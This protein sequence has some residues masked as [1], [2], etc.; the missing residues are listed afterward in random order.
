MG[1]KVWDMYSL[2]AAGAFNQDALQVTVVSQRWR[3]SAD[4]SPPPPSSAQHSTG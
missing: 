2:D 3:W 1:D 4:P